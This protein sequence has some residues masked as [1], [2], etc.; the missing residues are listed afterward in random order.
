MDRGIELNER[1]GIVV[2]TLGKR[3]S[4]LMECLE[5]IRRAG[6]AHICI[7]APS[8]FD[9]GLIFSSGLADQLVVDPGTGLSNAINKGI[10]ELPENVVYVNWLGDD[11]Q[12]T[13]NTITAAVSVLDAEPKIV[14]VYGS[15]DY[16]DPEGRLI[17][18]NKSGQWA[19]PLLHFGPDLVPQP[20]ALYRRST[21][22]K[23][24]G[25]SDA[26]DWA[27]D[28]DLLLKLKKV[29]KLKFL[30]ATLSKFRWHP[31]S[32]SV[33]GRIKSVKEASEV[34]V[35]HLPGFLKPVSG[36]WEYAV[37]RATLLAGKRVSARAK[38]SG[39]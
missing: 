24:G 1:V 2:P 8:S 22:E 10:S 32:L 18:T 14:L 9:G 21:F 19:A 28:F 20:G 39:N 7:V 36:L 4:Y 15:C 34:R 17:W 31:E 3:P 5:S 12:L 13:D 38:R 16:L 29:G 35:S 23:V 26:Y 37:M 25:L 30:N 11:D 27:F 33:G 6:Q